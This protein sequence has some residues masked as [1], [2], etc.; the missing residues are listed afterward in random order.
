MTDDARDPDPVIVMHREFVT[1]ILDETGLSKTG[2]A[3]LAGV[4]RTTVTRLFK[5]DAAHALSGRTLAALAAAGRVSIPPGIAATMTAR[6]DRQVLWRAFQLAME[7]V[8]RGLFGRR[9]WRAVIDVT[10]LGYDFLIERREQGEDIENDTAVHRAL[11][12]IV[13]SE[14]ATRRAQYQ[15]EE[16]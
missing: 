10:S 4:A 6:L 12:F 3:R 1:S 13:E 14:V 7:K 5:E 8:P 15:P 9:H 16:E 2:L 11:N